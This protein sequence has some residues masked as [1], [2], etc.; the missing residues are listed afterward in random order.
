MIASASLK[1]REHL[2][3]FQVGEGFRGLIASASLKRT[4]DDVAAG[5]R[6][7]RFRGL[8]A[9]ASLKRGRPERHRA[10]REQI[11]RLDCLGLI[12]ASNQDPVKQMAGFRGLI[13][14]AS[15]KLSILEEKVAEL[16]E[17]PRLDCLGLIEAGISGPRK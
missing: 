3:G 6:I 5:A 2:C 16:R 10:G 7:A 1:H 11:P 8:I 4:D 13:A 14:S 9:S 17:I 12:E 15:L